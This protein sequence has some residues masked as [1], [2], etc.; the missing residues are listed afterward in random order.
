M[1]LI[2]STA[3]DYLK[4]IWSAL[5]WGGDP[6]TIKGL[7]ARFGISAASASDTIKRLVGQGLV[8]HEPYRPI[9][10]TSTGEKQAVRVVRRHRLIETFLVAQLGYSWDEVHD[11]AEA[12]EHAVSD[13]MID[14]MDALL[15][16]PKADPHGDPIPN[17]SGEVFYP[18]DAIRVTDAAPG[19]YTVIR[20]SDDDSAQLAVFEA[21][22]LVTD[23]LLTV[24]ERD[25]AGVA[26]VLVPGGELALTPADA[27]AVIVVPI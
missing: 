6:M 18:A 3:E 23:V 5:E 10:L 15:G 20:I 24:V 16:S 19:K 25:S 7:A 4:V 13:L 9:G 22:G 21:A 8:L 14:R 26:R 17:R 1:Q 2:S 12:L 11:E 27:D